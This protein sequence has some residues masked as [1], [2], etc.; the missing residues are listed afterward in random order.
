MLTGKKFIPDTPL[1]CKL[2]SK[3]AEQQQQLQHFLDIREIPAVQMIFCKFL[4]ENIMLPVNADGSVIDV[5]CILY[6]HKY[7]SKSHHACHGARLILSIK[8]YFCC[9]KQGVMMGSYR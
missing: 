8:Q 1:N 2:Q 4:S 7:W 9:P 3:K 5:D 6:Q